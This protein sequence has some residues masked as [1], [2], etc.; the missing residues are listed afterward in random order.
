MLLRST[1]EI[2]RLGLLEGFRTIHLL[3]PQT[4]ESLRHDTFITRPL[5]GKEHPHNGRE[6]FYPL[7]PS[8]NPCFLLSASLCTNDTAYED[9]QHG[10][11]ERHKCRPCRLDACPSDFVRNIGEEDGPGCRVTLSLSRSKPTQPIF[12]ERVPDLG[13]CGQYQPTYQN[14]SNL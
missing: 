1:Q 10:D 13:Q 9:Q 14:V 2:Y 4:I 8:S 12:H 6:Q 7:V 11:Y 3:H 5:N